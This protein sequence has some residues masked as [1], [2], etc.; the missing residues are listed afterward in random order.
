M[1]RPPLFIHLTREHGQQLKAVAKASN[2]VLRSLLVCN[3]EG[4]LPMRS[5]DT[6]PWMSRVLAV[7]TDGHHLIRNLVRTMEPDDTWDPTYIYTTDDD[8]GRRDCETPRPFR[9]TAIGGTIRKGRTLV[10]RIRPDLLSDGEGEHHLLA[11]DND[12]APCRVTIN[13]DV[14]SY[15]D[16][17]ALTLPTRTATVALNPEILLA[18]AKGMVKLDKPIVLHL[19]L[20]EDGTVDP[21]AP[22][23]ASPCDDL[24][25]G[26]RAVIMPVRHTAHTLDTVAS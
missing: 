3:A 7:S 2:P 24:D 25:P 6:R 15:P 20:H 8:Y 19:P 26:T 17:R 5:R 22:I 4:H 18:M 1:A 9:I 13:F 14:A 23:Q 11:Y 21:H 10:L 12:M 16:W